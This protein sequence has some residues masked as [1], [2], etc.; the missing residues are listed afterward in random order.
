M[1][2]DELKAMIARVNRREELVAKD[3]NAG[4]GQQA[5]AGIKNIPQAKIIYKPKE[6][7][8]DFGPVAVMINLSN[9]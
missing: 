4:L 3:A 9:N 1:S 2:E 7:M 5:E 6:Y 8:M